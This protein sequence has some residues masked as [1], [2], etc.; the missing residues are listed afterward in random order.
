[1]KRREF[2]IAAAL[3]AAVTPARA[4]GQLRRY[5][6]AAEEVRWDYAPDGK[7]EM[8]GTPFNEAEEVF[9]QPGPA[10][11]GRVYKKARYI[12][13]SDA[14]F[15]TKLP[16][17]DPS[18]GIL[19]PVIRA[20]VGDEIEVTFKNSTTRPLSVHPHGVF[21]D[22]LSEGSMTNDST[23]PEQMKDDHVPPGETY[24]YHWKVPERAGPAVADPSS[25]VW[26]YHS[27]VDEARDT[28]TGLVGPMVITRAGM[29]KDNGS[30]KDVDRE[31]F[32]L[33]AIFDENLSL[34]IHQMMHTLRHP[35]HDEDEE[36]HE[37]NLM[38]SINGFV[39]GNMPMPTMKVG[40]KVRWYLMA[41][42]TETDLHT[43]HWHGNT[44][45]VGGHRKDVVELLPAT[46][47]VADMVP[48]NPGIWMFHCHVNDHLSAGM[49]GRYQVLP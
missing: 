35:P 7:D 18:L 46:T 21:Y 10:R 29:A 2:L 19:G 49:T 23:P 48:D 5:F 24:V 37:S 44:V 15:S 41:L 8:M 39:M 11:I 45:V 31:V 43:P 6:I 27:H 17:E 13:Y 42:G 38:H 32:S 3:A 30:P 9:V 16:Q 20:E 4:A 36:F 47:L 25:V 28:N 12:G 22:K 33:F 14:T 34:Y 26:L 40:E 1:M